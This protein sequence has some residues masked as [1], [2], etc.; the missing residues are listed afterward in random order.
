MFIEFCN[1]DVF[2]KIRD[3]MFKKIFRFYVEGFRDMTWGKSLWL[4]I[5]IK[6]FLIF[7][8]MKFFFFSDTIEN[9]YKTDEEVGMQVLENI[10]NSK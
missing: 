2:F 6:L 8:I 4:L 3:K 9:K 5:L 7:F 1:D 10:T